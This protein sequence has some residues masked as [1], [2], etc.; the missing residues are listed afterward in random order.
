MHEVVFAIILWEIV[1]LFYAT[2]FVRCVKLIAWNHFFLAFAPPDG[3][4]LDE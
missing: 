4:D 1:D 2:I 3:N